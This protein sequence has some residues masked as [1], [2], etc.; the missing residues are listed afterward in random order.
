M[1]LLG[2]PLVVTL[3]LVLVGVTVAALTLWD[4]VPGPAPS[5]VGQ[6]LGMLVAVQVV[7]TLLTA[8]AVN[9]YGYFY[10]SW[11]DLFGRSAHGPVTVRRVTAASGASDVTA[12]R[13]AEDVRVLGWSSP[14][15]YASKGQ[16]LSTTIAGPGTGLHDSAYVFL[17]PQYFQPA[18]RHTRFAAFEALTGY[19]G[20]V[21]GMLDRLDV[22][23]TLDTAVAAHQ[24]EPMVAVLMDP[25]VVP[26]RDTEC[27]D[28]P[29]GPQVERYF[30]E[31]VPSVVSARFRVDPAHWGVMGYSTGGYCAAKLVLDHPDRFAAGVGLSGYYHAISDRTTGS[32]WGGST[33]VQR[34]NSPEWVVRHEADPAVSFLATIGSLERGPEGIADTHDFVS[35]VRPPMSASVIVVRGGAH[36]YTDWGDIFPAAVRWMSARLSLPTGSHGR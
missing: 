32:L 8:A 5:R 26:P 14:E 13:Y 15:E 16:L 10:G 25:Q 33:V 18:Y 24:A 21:G 29:G 20:Y 23:G 28:I 17:P 6:R 27:T 2:W 4:R 36:N 12:L 11:S 7:A 35:G 31:D 22:P 30:G 1:P 34:L 9:N 19:P 3:A